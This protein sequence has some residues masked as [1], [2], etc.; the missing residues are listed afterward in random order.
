MRNFCEEEFFVLYKVPCSFVKNY[1][2]VRK[3]C[4]DGMCLSLECKK[5]STNPHSLL[6]NE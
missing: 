3:Y 5:G 4:E 2:K 6:Q 1:A